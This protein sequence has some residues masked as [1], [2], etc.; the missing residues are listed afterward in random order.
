MPESITKIIN[1]NN[2]PAILLIF[3]EEEFLISKSTEVLITKFTNPPINYQFEKYDGT[4]VNLEDIANYANTSSFFGDKKIVLIKD[5]DKSI[6]KVQKKNIEHTRFYNYLN[7]PN[8]NTLLVIQSNNNSLNGLSKSKTKSSNLPYPYDIITQKFVWIEY[9]KV[10]QSDYESWVRKITKNMKLEIEPDAIQMLISRA[11]DSLRTLWNEIEKLQIF[12]EDRTKVSL[13]DVLEVSGSTKELNVFDLQKYVMNRDL[14][15]SIQT[16]NKLLAYDRQEMLIISILQKFFLQLF[17]LSEMDLNQNKYA[18]AQKLGVNAYFLDDY[19]TALKKYN[20]N[21][22]ANA[23]S[24]LMY[25][26]E[27]IKSY[28]S[29]N[30]LI[31]IRMVNNIINGKR[32]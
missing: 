29:D 22:I 31:M 11:G 5:F 20:P 26:D 28:G 24:E 2:P 4:E 13:Q 12:M 3:G 7:N 27:Q 14:K 25:A 10:W 30:L 17:K 32:L 16:L 8:E 19:L 9:P 15:N 21:F 1:E 6:G 18:L 23:L